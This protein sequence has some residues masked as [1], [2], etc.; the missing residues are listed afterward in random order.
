MRKILVIIIL[1]IA[2]SPIFAQSQSGM[3]QERELI[4]GTWLSE[5]GSKWKL[6]FLSD[7][8]CIQYSDTR[9]LETDTYKLSND[10]PQCGEEVL[11]DGHASY[12]SLIDRATQ[13]EMCY[14]IY[15]LTEEYLNIRPL[16]SGNFILFVKLP[17]PLS[18]IKALDRPLQAEENVTEE[19]KHL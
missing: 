16:N 13:D 19:I 8:T 10:S 4:V 1:G 9:I 18:E 5:T 15:G 12:L 14:E 2:V 17:F 6:E 7:G 3:Q 11:A